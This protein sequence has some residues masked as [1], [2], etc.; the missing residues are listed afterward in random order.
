MYYEAMSSI[1]PL[2]IDVIIVY[3]VVDHQR[4]LKVCTHVDEKDAMVN[5]FRG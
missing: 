3:K 4:V 5:W 2:A 1:K